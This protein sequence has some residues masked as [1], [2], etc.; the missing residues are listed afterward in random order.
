MKPI[1]VTKPSCRMRSTIG[2]HYKKACQMFFGEEFQGF[3]TADG[4]RYK[5]D[6]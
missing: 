4:D 6:Y 1:R 2:T 3:I 5:T